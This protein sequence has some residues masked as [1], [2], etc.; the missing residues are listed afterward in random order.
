MTARAAAEAS[1]L[2][3]E[4]AFGWIEATANLGIE[5]YDVIT[6]DGTDV[7]VVGITETWDRGELRQRLDLA[8]VDSFGVYQG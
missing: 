3:A 2:A 5:L 8:E 7:R 6:V 4:L 1:K